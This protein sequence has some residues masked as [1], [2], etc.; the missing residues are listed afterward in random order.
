MAEADPTQESRG[1]E[2]RLGDIRIW[3]L[4]FAGVFVALMVSVALQLS[5]GYYDARYVDVDES[6]L[7][8]TEAGTRLHLVLR[9]APRHGQ[10]AHEVRPPSDDQ[11]L[12]TIV[13]RLS[14]QGAPAPYEDEDDRRILDIDLPDVERVR[15]LDLRWAREEV[16]VIERTAGRKGGD[17]S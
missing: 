13:V 2:S 12:Y 6:T 5:R 8:A 1:P 11:P 15:V 16:A 10:L 17:G 4:V 9:H 3:G 14:A 7:T